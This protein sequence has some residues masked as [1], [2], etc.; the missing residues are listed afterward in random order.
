MRRITLTLLTAAALAVAPAAASA[1]TGQQIPVPGP[2]LT[3]LGSTPMVELW[4]GG[5]GLPYLGST[6]SYN[7]GDWENTLRAYHDTGVYEQQI[8]K[9]DAV[10]ERWLTRAARPG[11][12]KFKFKARSHG[13]GVSIVRVSSRRGDHEHGHEHKHGNRG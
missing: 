7:A 3:K 2:I 10:A 8:D 4:D 6:T 11:N 1:Q 12:R 5:G 9:V 13:R